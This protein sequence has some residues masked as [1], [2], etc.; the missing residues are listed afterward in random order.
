MPK[1]LPRKFY[2][3]NTT[4]LA[5]ALLG[6]RLVR[7][8][9]GKRYSGII[10][11]TE[12]Y[13]GAIDQA[14]HTWKGRKSARNSSMYLEGGHA[15]VYFVYGMHYCFNVVAKKANE[16]E[17]VLIRALNPDE[18]TSGA[19]NGP[20]KLCKAL[21][22]TKALDGEDLRGETI[23]IEETGTGPSAEDIGATPRIGVDYAGEAAGWPLRF[24]WKGSA[25][26]SRREGK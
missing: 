10:V 25:N 1:K 16:P 9:R 4:T 8:W 20:A 17:A 7:V 21:R 2:F 11:E 18:N 15:Y 24:Y 5:K 19:T 22:I 13:L 6:K 14:A 23:F 26:L 3:Q 12:A